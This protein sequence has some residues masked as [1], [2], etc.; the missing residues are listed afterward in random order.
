MLNICEMAKDT[1]IIT[2]EG[3]IGNHTQAFKWYILVILSEP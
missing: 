2:M 3:E 1:A